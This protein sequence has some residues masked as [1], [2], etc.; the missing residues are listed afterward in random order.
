MMCNA[1][2]R[3]HAPLTMMSSLSRPNYIFGTVLNL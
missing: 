3:W 2:E 1:H